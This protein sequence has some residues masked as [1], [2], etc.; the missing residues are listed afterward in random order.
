MGDIYFTLFRHHRL[1]LGF[2]VLGIIAAGA[3]YVLNKP[4]YTSVAKVLVKY[5]QD[6]QSPNVAN[7]TEKVATPDSRGET[8]MSSEV[9]IFSSFDLAQTVAREFGAEKILAKAGGGTNLIAAAMLLNNNLR[10]ENPKKTSTILIT[11][12]HPDPELVQPLLKEFI[13]AY[14][15]KHNEIHKSLGAM[16]DIMK[17]QRE[18]LRQGLADTEAKLL[19]IQ[20]NNGIFSV[21]DSKKAVTDRIARLNQE[22]ASAET[23]LADNKATLASWLSSSG[24][25]A[26]SSNAGPVAVVAPAT[27]STNPAPATVALKIPQD[28]QD[29][30]KVARGEQ[31]LL[32]KQ[33]R[34]LQRQ[35][36]D[37]HP[38]VKRVKILAAEADRQVAELESQYAD[39]RAVVA[40]LPSS[41]LAGLGTTN[42][43]AGLSGPDTNRIAGLEARVALLKTLIKEAS[44]G[45]SQL[46]DAEMKINQLRRQRDLQE[47][48]V[49]NLQ[50]TLDQVA[51]DEQLGPGKVTGIPEIQQPSVPIS[52]S[53]A[54][55]KL[56]LMS[57][58]GCVGAG[59]V[60]AFLI[61]LVLDRSLKRPSEVESRSG[62]PLFVSIPD[63]PSLVRDDERRPPLPPSRQLGS[64]AEETGPQSDVLLPAVLNESH[65]L[66]PFFETLRDRL[67]AFFDKNNMT[68]KPKLVAVTGCHANAGVTTV[69]AGLAASLSNSGDGNVLVVDM[70]NEGGAVQHFFRGKPQ[71]GLQ[72]ALDEGR[73]GEARVQDNLFVVSDRDGSGG[74]P[75]LHKRLMSLVPK[76]KLSTYDYIIFDLPPMSQTSIAPRV[77]RFM[78]MVLVVAEAERTHSEL[79]RQSSR[80]LEES[81]ANV[82][83]VLNR[84]RQHVPDRLSHELL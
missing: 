48:N 37:A 78:D 2:L 22:L 44:S 82:G 10:V 1:L 66:N 21:E 36:T 25:P 20:T 15:N 41:Q 6:R 24:S 53:S 75:I 33:E 14:K 23:Q 50:S 73:R 55:L 34:E 79:L 30:Y 81:G 70:K 68:H 57:F 46:V 59:L 29:A 76:L 45:A 65:G 8:I 49:R 52:S 58:F 69:V 3:A 32:R 17:R 71:L 4:K 39:I 35:Y 11:L 40:I 51:V 43:A 60:L 28:K 42:V 5:I 84:T 80:L 77:A 9:E 7:T 56:V 13:A 27:V 67:V 62:V 63:R 47:A 64:A 16:D 83:A 12:T 74:A 61:D 19:E 72:E 38:R 54:R 18:T 26:A 31:E